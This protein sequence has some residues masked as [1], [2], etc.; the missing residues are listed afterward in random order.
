MITMKKIFFFVLS[1]AII[2]SCEKEDQKISEKELL[3]F[4]FKKTNN[5]SLIF[6]VTGNI[7]GNTVTVSVLNN[8]NLKELKATFNSSPKS[9]VKIGNIIQKSGSTPNDFTNPITYKIYAE[10]GSVAD[11]KIIVTKLEIKDFVEP[12]VKSKWMVYTYPYNASYPPLNGGINGRVGNACGPTALAKIFHYLKYPVNGNGII[13]YYESSSVRWQC[14]LSTLN[15]NYSNMP[16]ELDGT[17]VESDYKDVAKL[18]L[19]TGSVGHYLDIGN[20]DCT[21]KF[22]AGIAKYFKLDQNLKLINRWE[23]TKN[24]WE[25][26]LKSELSAGRPIMVAGR[27]KTSPAPWE[28]GNSDGH[29][30]I[31]DGYNQEGKFHVQYNFYKNGVPLEGYYDSDNL[32]E[33]YTAYNQA[34]I[35][36]KPN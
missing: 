24:E 29:W 12:L 30:Y 31:L 4:A 13:D 14:D 11:Y 21:P 26:I 6:D 22:V 25:Y 10:D 20:R 8:T 23:L 33:I 35:G 7:N 18:F 27:T 2:T 28:N 17:A 15:L 19:A 16:N 34:I 32:G 5:S 36:F 3:D 9:T 1:I